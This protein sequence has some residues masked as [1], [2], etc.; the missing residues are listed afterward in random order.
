MQY[1]LIGGFRLSS[2]FP[3]SFFIFCLLPFLFYFH[4]KLIPHLPSSVV[5]KNVGTLFDA[6]AILFYF[7]FIYRGSLK[8]VLSIKQYVTCKPLHSINEEKNLICLYLGLYILYF[9]SKQHRLIIK[10]KEK[11]THTYCTVKNTY[12]NIERPSEMTYLQVYMFVCV[13]VFFV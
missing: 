11:N 5:W 4:L 8:N 6:N 2:F 10:E 9:A 12:T 13:W 3:F 7:F 1:F